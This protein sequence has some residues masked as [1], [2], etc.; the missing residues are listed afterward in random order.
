MTIEKF[1]G[2]EIEVIYEDETLVVIN[3][4]AGIVANKTQTISEATIQDWMAAKI[5]RRAGD[6]E[7]FS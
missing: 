4:P 3:K 7:N 6:R 1:A 2:L 5:R